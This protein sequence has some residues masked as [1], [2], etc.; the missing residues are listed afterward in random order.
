MLGYTWDAN[1]NGV[2][3]MAVKSWNDWGNVY[4]AGTHNYQGK[5]GYWDRIVHS[6]VQAGKWYVQVVDGSGNPASNVAVVNFTSSC[7][8]STGPVQQAEVDFKSH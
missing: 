5:D 1:G 6:G 8:P 7:D 4:V 3:G 2:N